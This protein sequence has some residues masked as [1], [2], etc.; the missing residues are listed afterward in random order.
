MNYTPGPWKLT[1][2]GPAST[3]DWTIETMD[4]TATICLFPE[5]TTRTVG[6][7]TANTHLIVTAPEMFEFIRTIALGNTEIETLEKQARELLIKI[8][9][10]NY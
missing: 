1:W 7:V 10:G 2:E 9:Q 4:G 8:S 6:Q 5:T 3:P